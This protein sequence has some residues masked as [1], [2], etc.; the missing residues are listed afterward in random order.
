MDGEEGRT[1]GF[2]SFN[3]H[4]KNYFLIIFSKSSF[5]SVTSKFGVFW[6]NEVKEEEVQQV[7]GWEK[8]R[9]RARSLL[10]QSNS[11]KFSFF[12]SSYH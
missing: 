6:E 4:N 1:L 12:S 5:T 2:C 11:I 8:R 3:K 10:I 7:D 9:E